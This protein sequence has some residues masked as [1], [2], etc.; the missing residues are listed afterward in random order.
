MWQCCELQC[1]KLFLLA[2]G[3]PTL[4]ASRHAIGQYFSQAWI[5]KKKCQ[6]RRKFPHNGGIIQCLFSGCLIRSR[7]HLP[8]SK[9]N[10]F[11]RAVT[12]CPSGTTFDYSKFHIKKIMYEKLSSV[13]FSRNF[14]VD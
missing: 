12:V 4:E 1:G 7:L 9:P 14:F 13:L 3:G 5:K 2:G 11:P 8:L 10:I 6:A